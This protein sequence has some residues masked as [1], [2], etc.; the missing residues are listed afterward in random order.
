[1]FR[2]AGG[3]WVD[4]PAIL[5]DLVAVAGVLA[6]EMTRLEREP[7]DEQLDATIQRHPA[8]RGL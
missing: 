8:G 5:R 6:E 3:L 1:M 2:R 4:D 7:D